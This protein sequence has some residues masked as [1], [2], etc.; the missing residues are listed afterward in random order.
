MGW[1]TLSVKEE[2]ADRFKDLKANVDTSEDLSADRFLTLLLN[3]WEH[4]SKEESNGGSINAEQIAE[5]IELLRGHIDM[6]MQ[7]PV[8]EV[9][10]DN[11][12]VLGRID[13][14]ESQ[15]PR[16]IKEELR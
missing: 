1:T 2:T 7:E 15:L 6:M 3:G 5:E 4:G 8:A 13:D 14:L 16:K 12:D 10:T 11:S 9:K